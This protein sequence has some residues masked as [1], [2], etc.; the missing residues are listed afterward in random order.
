MGNFKQEIL[1]NHL[2]ELAIVDLIK[3]QLEICIQI[4]LSEKSE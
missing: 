3:V 2:I 1:I 4:K